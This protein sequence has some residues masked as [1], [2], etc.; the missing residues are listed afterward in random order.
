[1]RSAVTRRAGRGAPPGITA[2]VRQRRLV[3][4]CGNEGRQSVLDRF[5][6]AVN[7]CAD[8]FKRW[9][10]TD[11]AREVGQKRSGGGESAG[12][13]SGRRIVALLR[14]AESDLS[15]DLAHMRRG[16]GYV[17]QHLAQR[18]RGRHQPPM[19]WVTTREVGPEHG[20][21]DGAPCRVLSD[22]P[23]TVRRRAEGAS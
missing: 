23:E 18:P 2:Q 6:D 17:H 19:S 16:T 10:G 3:S 4:T 9:L 7:M 8:E 12:H 22:L 20:R 15:V 11:T 5:G 1:M 14:T 21:G 13:Q